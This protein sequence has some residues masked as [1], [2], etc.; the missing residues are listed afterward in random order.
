ML[1]HFLIFRLNTAQNLE[2]GQEEVDDIKVKSHRCP[3]KFIICVALDKIVSVIDDVSTEYKS[4]EHTI[5]GH[6]YRTK[7]EK[8]LHNMP[9]NITQIIM[10]PVK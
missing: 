9:Q 10:L 7:R 8:G 3:N 1:K 2:Q 6:R 5:Y 4:R